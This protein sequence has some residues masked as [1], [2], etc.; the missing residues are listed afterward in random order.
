VARAAEI[1]L[2]G[3]PH[4][5]SAIVRF[6]PSVDR[7]VPILLTIGE[8]PAV[9]KA[10]LRS[11]GEGASQL[12]LRLPRETPPGR[13]EGEAS[14]GGKQLGAVVEVEAVAKLRLSPRRVQFSLEPGARTEFTVALA[15]NGNV[16]FDVPKSAAFDLDDSEGQDRAL[17]RALRATLEPGERRVD[18][19]FDDLRESHG[20]EARL[21]V[22]DGAG[23]LTAGESRELR[24]SLDVPKTL[25]PGRD[26]LGAWP[27][28]NTGLVVIVTA[29]RGSSPGPKGKAS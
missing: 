23:T 1:T 20:G 29:T 22:R 27:L 28:G 16:P 10:V 8:Q 7:I 4:N 6:G 18:R 24:C 12:R 21:A 15:N 25:V 17:G 5:T 19:F 11:F 14:V 13:Y 26:Y 2:T 3:P 9:Y